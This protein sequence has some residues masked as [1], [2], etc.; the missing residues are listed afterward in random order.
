MSLDFA[1]AADLF[2]ASE[3][4]LAA[5]L[6]IT[7]ADLRELRTNP[8]RANRAVEEK[9]AQVLTERGKA[10]QRVAELLLESD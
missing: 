2:T 5:A 7:I 3:Q 10:M 6:G 8:K 4:E 9:L 1:R